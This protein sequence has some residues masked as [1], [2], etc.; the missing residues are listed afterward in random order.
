MEICGIAI[1]PYFFTNEFD[2]YT[3]KLKTEYNIIGFIDGH[4]H[5]GFV[6]NPIWVI[7]DNYQFFLLMLCSE[8]CNFTQLCPES[9]K[10]ILNF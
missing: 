6:K 2:N 5:A 7:N 9:Y 1:K 3:E 8:N 10:K 4:I